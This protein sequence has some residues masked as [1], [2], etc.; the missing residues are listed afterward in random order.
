MICFMRV[1]AENPFTKGLTTRLQNFYL[2]K[3]KP[4]RVDIKGLHAR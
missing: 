3:E 1:E 2:G 4:K